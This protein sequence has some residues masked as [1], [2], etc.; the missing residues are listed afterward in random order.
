MLL[1]QRYN[2]CLELLGEQAE[3][4]EELKMDILEMRTVYQAQVQELC[5]KVNAS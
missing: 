3:K 2:A 1:N 4:V 5:A